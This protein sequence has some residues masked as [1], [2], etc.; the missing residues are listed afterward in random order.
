MT[1]SEPPIRKQPAQLS[2]SGTKRR[3]GT[4]LLYPDKLAYVSSQAAHWGNLIGF[5]V[6]LFAVGIFL[7]GFH[8]A[9]LLAIIIGC[10]AGPLLALI[11]GVAGARIGAAIA[12]S[13]AAGRVPQGVGVTVIPL[14]SIAILQARKSTGIGADLGCQSLLVFTADG[15][16]YRFGENLEYSFGVRLDRWSA[17]LASALTARGRGVV[18]TPQGMTVTRALSA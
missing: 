7:W 11:G 8:G 16:E 3:Q 17:D 4:V 2:R 13:R 1:S 6:V 15:T 12:E 5:V 18:T 10:V 9:A 14:D